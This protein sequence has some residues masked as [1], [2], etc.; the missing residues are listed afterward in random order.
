M[1]RIAQTLAAKGAR[2]GIGM[3][4]FPAS[5]SQTSPIGRFTA[6]WYGGL[7]HASAAKVLVA[8]S[9][10]VERAPVTLGMISPRFIYPASIAARLGHLHPARRYPRNSR[11][12]PVPAAVMHKPPSEGWVFACVRSLPVQASRRDLCRGVAAEWRPRHPCRRDS[13]RRRIPYRRPAARPLPRSIH[14]R[15]RSD[16]LRKALVQE[17]TDKGRR[18]G[19]RRAPCPCNGRN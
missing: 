4:A 9:A 6:R 15:L 19:R 2:I 14:H 13:N 18:D 12:P 3:A 8:T 16:R 11:W 1:R 7:T 10:P 17:R 5:A